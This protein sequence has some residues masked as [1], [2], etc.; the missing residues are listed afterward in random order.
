MAPT[1]TTLLSVIQKILNLF[2]YLITTT[3]KYMYKVTVL[4]ISRYWHLMSYSE[5]RCSL[6]LNSLYAVLWIILKFCFADMA[7][8]C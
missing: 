7:V 2:S 1:V 5:V 3:R 6:A 4:F 8:E